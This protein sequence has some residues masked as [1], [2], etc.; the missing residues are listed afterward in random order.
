MAEP[1]PYDAEMFRDVKPVDLDPNSYTQRE[2][3]ENFK[4]SERQVRDLIERKMGTG[5]W[6]R[7]TKWVNNRRTPSYRPAK[8]QSK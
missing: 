2:I 1:N 5:E 7:V 6:E 8:P 3:Q 4:M